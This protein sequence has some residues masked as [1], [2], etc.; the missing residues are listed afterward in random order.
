MTERCEYEQRDGGKSTR[1]RS[2]EAIVEAIT[3]E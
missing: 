1:G 2:Y 3:K